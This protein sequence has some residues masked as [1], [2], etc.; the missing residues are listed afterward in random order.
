MRD[1]GW[2]RSYALVLVLCLTY[3]FPANSP[4]DTADDKSNITVDPALFGG[5]QYRS[6]DFSRGGRSTAVAGVPSKP[7]IYYFGS[8]GGGVW[9]TTDAG[10][11]WAN[12]SDG[13]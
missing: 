7:L 2:I 11:T 1:S 3:S 13:F 5:L 10:I 4:A 12:V 8:T 6:L 9:K